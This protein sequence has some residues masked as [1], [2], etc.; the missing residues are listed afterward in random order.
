MRWMPKSDKMYYMA[1]AATGNNVVLFDPATFVEEVVLK[2]IPSEG[3]TWS[4]TED[5]LIYYP[6]EKGQAEQG[7][8][9]RVVTPRDR[10]PGFRG[11]NFL[12]KYD[13]KKGTTERLTYGYHSTSLAITLTDCTFT[14]MNFNNLVTEKNFRA[15][16]VIQ[17]A[18]SIQNMV[19]STMKVSFI[20]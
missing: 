1:T 2:E 4:P 20:R 6:S 16:T 14:T 19:I 18:T 15:M 17:D 9:K 11:R 7:P 8:L 13:I 3:F 5:F 10:I 12:A